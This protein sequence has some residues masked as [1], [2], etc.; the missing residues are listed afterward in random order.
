LAKGQPK[1][2]VVRGESS[3]SGVIATVNSDSHT[4]FASGKTELNIWV[5]C[6]TE[7]CTGLRAVI[8]EFSI[9]CQFAGWSVSFFPFG[10]EFTL[11][12]KAFDNVFSVKVK[13][14][15]EFG[16]SGLTN[17]KLRILEG[18]FEAC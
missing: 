4:I 2:S 6:N 7:C 8:F 15:L 12:L 13:G 11:N 17:S 1:G 9:S 16:F 5:R 18:V 10:I 3:L 14:T